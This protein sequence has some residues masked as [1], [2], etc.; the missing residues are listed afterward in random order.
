MFA[1]RFRCVFLLGEQNKSIARCPAVGLLHEQ[2]T[3][4]A[5]ENVTRFLPSEKKVN[6]KMINNFIKKCSSSFNYFFFIVIF[7]YLIHHL[8]RDAIVRQT[9]HSHNY[10]S[11]P[12]EESVSLATRSSS[13]ANELFAG[14]F[15][16]FDVTRADVMLMPLQRHV[17][18]F[19]A[20]ESHQRLAVTS[21]L[22][23]QTQGYAT[24][25]KKS[26]N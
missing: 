5:V 10:L 16:H 6:L 7:L 12:R 8:F 26:V 2:H 14:R 20:H 17:F 1:Q 25:T 11:S 21:A 18:V 22:V 24:P 9:S 15:V 13:D 3:L 4:L 23:T 19:F